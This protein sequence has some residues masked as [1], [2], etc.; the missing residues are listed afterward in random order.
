[1][2]SRVVFFLRVRLSVLAFAPSPL[3]SFALSQDQV[4][5][6]ADESHGEADP[7]QDVGGAVGAL[8]EVDR[9]KAVFLIRVDGG[10]DHHAQSWR[11]EVAR[12]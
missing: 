1:M 2:C 4:H 12:G 9:V 3:R 6:A 5:E 10:C 8:L 7:G 11:E